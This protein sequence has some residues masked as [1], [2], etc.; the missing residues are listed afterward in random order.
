MSQPQA[1]QLFESVQVRS[2]WDEVQEKWYFSV[3]DVVQVLT[4]SARPRK[5]WS[6]L[7]VKLQKEGSE[8][9]EKIGQLKMRSP[10]GK[11]R[12]TDAADVQT[13]LRLIQS[14]PSPKA[15]PF[16]R[17]LAQVGY[18]RVK[19]IE[20]PELASARARE[21]Y[22]AKG[23]PQAWIEKRLRSISVRGELTDEW[24]ARGVAEGREYSI[25]TAEIARATF[26]ITPTEH[27]QLKGLEAVKTDNNLRDHMTDL[28]LIFTMLGEASTTEIARRSDAQGFNENHT[29]AQEGG[30]IAG[31]ARKALEAKTGSKVVSKTNFLAAPPAAAKKIR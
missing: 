21:L 3:V 19:E 16:K 8:V 1:I 29:S 12:E 27:S 7:K 14:I 11:A 31:N 17:W 22:Q 26:G 30:K 2:H 13:L 20:N 10:D 25:L 15:E 4:D 23:Y 9:S 28:E 24:K 6:D 5:Y 18:E